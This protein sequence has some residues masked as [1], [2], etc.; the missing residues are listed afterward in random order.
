MSLAHLFVSFVGG[1]AYLQSLS[2]VFSYIVSAGSLLGQMFLV[3]VAKWLEISQYFR[4][5]H[6]H[7]VYTF[8]AEEVGHCMLPYIRDQILELVNKSLL[9]AVL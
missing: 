2:L 9:V 3:L 8:I 5:N 4:I 7:L 6:L 1:V